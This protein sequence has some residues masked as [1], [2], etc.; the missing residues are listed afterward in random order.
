[1]GQGITRLYQWMDKSPLRAL[2]LL[3]ALLLAGCM[4]WDPKR[5]AANSSS[6]E[7]WQGLLMMWAVCTGVIHG[8]G[9]RP[10]RLRWQAFFSPLPAWIVLIFG[11]A[12][13]FS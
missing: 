7:I 13:F 1:M 9:F 4:F 5:F 6:L 8:V 12:F 3:M 10:R 2:S 11:L